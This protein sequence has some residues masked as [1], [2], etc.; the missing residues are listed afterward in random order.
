MHRLFIAI[1]PPAVV[2]DILLSLQGGVSAARWQ[3]FEQLH[4]TLRFIGEVDRHQADDIYAALGGVH[5]PAFEAALSDFNVFEKEG[6][7]QSLYVGVNASSALV[8]L[9]NK[10]D[11][12]LRRVGV[13]PDARVFTPH[14]TLARLNRSSG[15]LVDFFA[16]S[17]AP[18]L[19]F[20]VNDF[21]LFESSLTRERAVY[22]IIERYPLQPFPAATGSDS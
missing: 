4:I 21:C 15:P 11:Q 3:T 6:K 19:A 5:F 17:V 12:A 18:Q 10:M 22:E 7:P 20:S 8:A 1:D 16:Q 14:I 13:A 9:H 2:K